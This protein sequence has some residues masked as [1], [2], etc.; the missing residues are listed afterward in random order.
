MS[1]VASSSREACPT[2]LALCEPKVGKAPYRSPPSTLSLNKTQRTGLQ[3]PGRENKRDGRVGSTSPRSRRS[4]PARYRRASRGRER[5]RKPAFPDPPEVSK[6][7]EWSRVIERGAVVLAS[8]QRHSVSLPTNL[9]Q[10]A[11]TIPPDSPP[12]RVVCGPLLHGGAQVAPCGAMRPSARVRALHGQHEDLFARTY[13]RTPVQ[14]WVGLMLCIR[15]LIVE[16]IVEL[17]LHTVTTEI[18]PTV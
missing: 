17:R 4:P 12:T 3:D 7:S 16:H 10:A 11:R 14:L 2:C 5:A 9:A 13:C 18:V 15:Q 6:T 8:P 1:Q